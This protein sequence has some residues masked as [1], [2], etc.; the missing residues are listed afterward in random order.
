MKNW[1]RSAAACA[2][3]AA[4]AWT[5]C[6]ATAQDVQPAAQDAQTADPTALRG[7]MQQMGANLQAVTDAISREDW[8]TVAEL[9]PKIANHDQPPMLEKVKIL[10]WLNVDAPKFKGLDGEVEKA[11]TAMGE[12]A[13]KGDG[14]AVIADFAKVQQSCLA[15][16]A[17]YRQ[18]FID[19][20][21]G[22]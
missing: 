17:G 13:Q 18:K 15:C 9:A 22:K 21:Y 20:F 11:A 6:A 14:E 10:A 19:H 3:A 4:C 5:A 2:L 12:A 16:H 8:K 1:I 7:I